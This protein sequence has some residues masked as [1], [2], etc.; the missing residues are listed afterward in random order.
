MEKSTDISSLAT[1]LAAAQAE[2]S[3]VVKDAQNP[4]FRSS[5]ATLAAVRDT[6]IPVLARNKI[7]VVQM[8]GQDGDRVTLTTVL[9]HT[10]GEYISSTC[11]AAP[12][13]ADAQGL[14]SVVT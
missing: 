10:S 7:A 13:K 8:P 3:N 5:Y 11:S 12:T 4:H 6:V 2:L 14:G 9:M 1:A